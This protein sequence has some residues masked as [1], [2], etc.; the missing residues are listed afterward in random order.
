M[1]NQTEIKERVTMANYENKSISEVQSLA[2]QGD[3]EALFEM[4]WRMPDD[5]KRDPV[6]SCAWQDFFFEKAANAGHIDAKSRFAGSLINRVMNADD[7][8]KAMRYFEE[9]L[10]DY[11]AGRLVGDQEIDGI[12][13]HYWL[14]IML[15]EGYHTPRD[16]VRG[17]KLL[18][19]VDAKTNCFEKFGY[20]FLSKIGELYAEGLAQT[21]EEPSITDLDKAVKY[22]EIAVRKFNPEKDD[23]NNRGFLL[24]TKEM[25]EVQKNR[26]A[27][28]RATGDTDTYYAG[29]NERRMQMMEVSPSAQQRLDADKAAIA[30]LR[31][32]LARDGW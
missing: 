30:R 10:A 3:K 1:C 26:V 15:C 6:E 27:E 28:K 18:E 23:P 14:G 13:A 32:Q 9:L 29:A 5:V 22:L 11:N 12:L 21:G 31:Q 16:A 2:K 19:A 4:V 8:K 25:L 24:I 17:A 7:R 20:R